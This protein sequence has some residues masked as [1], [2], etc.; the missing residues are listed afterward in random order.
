MDPE[1]RHA[2]T[3]ADELLA[4]G[5]RALDALARAVASLA[6]Q[7]PP[8]LT[9]REV[10]RRG[11]FRPPEEE[12]AFAWFGRFLSVREGLWEVLGEVSSPVEGSLERVRDRTGW[13]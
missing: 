6:A 5:A 13:R 8:S 7:V 12:A 10:R 2:H 11:Y 3:V 4:G 9:D 1:G